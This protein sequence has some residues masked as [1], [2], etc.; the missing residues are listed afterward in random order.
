[1]TD[2]RP[3]NSVPNDPIDGLDFPCPDVEMPVEGLDIS[4]GD[5]VGSKCK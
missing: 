3:E 2:K 1:M 4:Y 5:S